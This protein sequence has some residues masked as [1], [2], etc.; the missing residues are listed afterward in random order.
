MCRIGTDGMIIV[1]IKTRTVGDY[2]NRFWLKES[3][4]LA[5]INLGG[6]VVELSNIATYSFSQQEGPKLL[7]EINFV[8]CVVGLSNIEKT[9]FLA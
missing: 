6:C 1:L 3:S 5:E 2:C 8:G 9:M 4:L 7:A